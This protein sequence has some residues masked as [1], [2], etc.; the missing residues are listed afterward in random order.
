MPPAGHGNGLQTRKRAL[1][2][3]LLLLGIGTIFA[4]VRR[5]TD[6]D[7]YVSVGRAILNGQDSY[8]ATPVGVD[9]W[10]PFFNLFCVPLAYASESSIYLA[11]ALWIVL[12]EFML[13]G[14]SWL[15]A[16]LLYNRGLSLRPDTPDL[17]VAAPGSYVPFLLV[18]PFLLN[19]FENLNLGIILLGV[20][21]GGLYLAESKREVAGG[22]MLGAAAAL[23]L[24]PGFFILYFAY[25]RQWRRF[26][27]SAASV[28]ALS[29][30]PALVF[31]WRRFWRDVALWRGQVNTL[32][33]GNPW[34]QSVYAMWLRFVGPVKLSTIYSFPGKG[35]YPIPPDPH[36][37]L[38]W[39]ISF[40][41]AAV[42]I[43]VQFREK[44]GNDRFKLLSEWSVLFLIGPLFS[45]VMW[46]HYLTVLW[47]PCALLVAAWRSGRLESW[48][49]WVVDAVLLVCAVVGALQFGGVWGHFVMIRVLTYSDVTIM[50]LVVVAGLLWLRRNA[51]PDVIG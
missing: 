37:R 45:P 44:P 29:L 8:L 46:R 49:R 30:S 14:I 5:V 28:A 9:T 24:M 50:T 11:R 20:M 39:R 4:Y 23:K 2:A 26:A 22:A 51:P 36:A 13:V 35:F 38:A 48:C 19:N 27:A 10:P 25:R 32:W 43:I 42:L 21:L 7:A 40:A 41:V 6:F 17:W 16:R 47:L 33:T 18:L 31:G 12:N 3:F 15:L 34:N 1:P